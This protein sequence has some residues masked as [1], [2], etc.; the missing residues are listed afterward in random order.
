M[1]DLL[2]LL[3]VYLSLPAV[4]VSP[5]F[6]LLVYAWLAYM[7]PQDVAWSLDESRLSLL[8][9]LLLLAGLVIG[10]I[11]RR[12]KLLQLRAETVLL[13]AMV[14]WVALS[15]FFAVNQTRTWTYWE[16]LAKGA[17][18]AVLTTGLVRNLKRLQ[19]L[20]SVIA[21]SLG[22][23]GLKYALFGLVRGGAKI[24]TG[25]G[26]FMTDNNGFAAALVMTIPLLTGVAITGEKRWLRISASICA[27]GCIVAVIFT[28][29]RGGLLGLGVVGILLIL[30]GKKPLLYLAVLIIGL[31]G[32]FLLTSESFKEAYTERA[33]TISEY[34]EDSSA[35][36]RLN[37]W[38]TAIEVASDYPLFGV[39][40]GN[41]PVVYPQ[42][43]DA[44]ARVAHNSF[45]QLLAEAGFP[46]ALM[47]VMLL[48]V[49]F[50]RLQLVCMDASAEPTILYFA[51]S[52]QISL[53]GYAVGAM[54][55]DL[56][57]FDLF[58]QVAVMGV[59]LQAVAKAEPRAIPSA[60]QQKTEQ[61]WRE[62]PVSAQ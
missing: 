53:A 21:M 44:K 11:R 23:L 62:A 22:L 48:V 27:V 17:L 43:S 14:G 60:R 28:F 35:M 45:F 3:V 47:W 39:G 34:Q 57:L 25:P 33:E 5:F 30:R 19:I 10:M 12:E 58:Y 54:F 24:H 18:I 38:K 16:M 1:R 52:L 55:L 2:V 6:G 7:R 20:F 51:R 26:G 46:A 15:C 56:A 37:A 50:L 9:A 36:G 29:S 32:T 13:M 59:C 8:V 41:L 49:S 4:V 42:Y 40:L 61:W 31:G